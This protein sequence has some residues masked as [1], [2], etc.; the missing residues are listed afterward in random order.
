MDNRMIFIAACLRG[1]SSTS[2]LCAEHGISRKTGHKWLARF[3]AGGVAGLAD[4]IH[5]RHTQQLKI[6][7]PTAM[8]I[9][10]LRAAH[11][12]WGPRKLLA[13]LRLDEPGGVWPS[14]STGGDLL[15]REGL[16][17]PRAHRRSRVGLSTGPMISRATPDFWACFSLLSDNVQATAKATYAR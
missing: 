6:D 14:A 12:T 9:I 17:E 1:L 11:Q 10:A 13:R 15:R 3:A 4:A 5:A 2:Q 16:S 7:G 8:R